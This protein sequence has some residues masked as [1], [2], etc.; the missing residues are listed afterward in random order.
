MLKRFCIFALIIV[1]ASAIFYN[2]DAIFSSTPEALGGRDAIH[3]ADAAIQHN[4]AVF[5]NLLLINTNQEIRAIN[6]N[7]RLMWSVPF[8]ARNPFLVTSGNHIL[9]ADRGGTDAIVLRGERILSNL[10]TDGEIFTGRIN[11]NGFV[12]L[13]TTADG[14]KSRIEVH[15][16]FGRKIYKWEIS[17]HYVLDV[18]VSPNN[19]NLVAALLRSD[20]EGI[21]GSLAFVDIENERIIERPSFVNA[22]ISAIRHD[23]NGNL[24]AIAD[25]AALF[26]DSEGQNIWNYSFDGRTLQ[27][28]AFQPTGN[29]FLFFRNSRNT[30]TLETL[31][32]ADKHMLGT[33]ELDFEVQNISINRNTVIAMGMREISR[34]DRYA[35]QRSHAELGVD[36]H[37]QGL[38]SDRRNIFIAHGNSIER[39][40]L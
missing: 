4:Y 17:E 26:Y 27:S 38:M 6:R 10:T 7:G 35:R 12:A 31:R 24:L 3:R 34:F 19:N 23:S 11:R 30:S 32:V 40:R 28:F 29:L 1:F 9:V 22:I 36:V 20:D 14:F 33:A 13:A 5:G 25:T 15:S 18:D 39:I 37:W 21:V 8:A 2:R 16:P